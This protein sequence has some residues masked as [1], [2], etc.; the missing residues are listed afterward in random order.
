MLILWRLISDFIE[1]LSHRP[2]TS[3]R[4]DHPAF[5]GGMVR[6]DITGFQ[7]ATGVMGPKD[8]RAWQVPLGHV[9]LREK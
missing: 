5:L 7:V 6:M 8:N 9:V 2:P 3:A 1:L 4:L